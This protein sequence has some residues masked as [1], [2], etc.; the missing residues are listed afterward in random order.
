MT[1]LKSDVDRDATHEWRN[2][3]GIGDS[4][5]TWRTKVLN[6][7]LTIIS[8]VVLA[9]MA[10]V[11][12]N[13]VNHPEQWLPALIFLALYVILVG[14]AVFR[15]MDVRW[16]GWGLLLIGYLAGLVAFAR[17]GLA[18]AGPIYVLALSVLAIILVG[19]RSGVLM[20]ALNAATYLVL[21]FLADSGGLNH[22]LIYTDNPLTW[23]S[24]MVEGASLGMLWVIVIVLLAYFHQ[25]H[26]ETLAAERQASEELAQAYKL[27]EQHKLTLEDRVE[28]RTRQLR[29]ASQNMSRA[30]QAKDKLLSEFRA[31]LDIIEYSVLLLD[32]DLRTRA[33]N[34]AFREMWGFTEDF[35]A[36]S[37]TLAELITY[38]RDTGLYD[39]PE[40][41]WDDYVEQK[42]EAV[43]QGEIPPTT[44]KLGDGRILR[45]QAMRLPDDG[46]ILTYFDI[47]DLM[48]QSEY[49][50]VLHET[51]LG[52]ISRLDLG[53]LL[54]ALVRRAGQL[55]DTSH[56]FIYLTSGDGTA[57]ECRVGV[58]AFS[59][60]IDTRMAPGEGLSGKIWQ[61]GQPMIV[62]DYD[63]W[64]GRASSFE[65]GLIS[66]IMGAPL[67]SGAQT[68]GVIGIAYGSDLDR[69]F[70]DDEV[71]LLNRFAELA[72]IALDNAQL[73]QAAQ[74]EKRYFQSLVL[75]NPVAVIVTSREGEV[76]SWNPAAED[77]F[78]YTSEEAVGRNVDD[79][80]AN[81]ALR[82]EALGFTRRGTDGDIVH[83]ITRRCR[84]DGSLVDVELLAVPMHVEEEESST[85]VIYHDI[86]ELQQARQEA[87]AANQAKSAF[88]ATMSHEIRTPMNAVIGMTSLLLDTPLTLEQQEFVETIR[89][90]GDALLTIINDIL[91]F[92]KIE[93]GRMTLENQP[94]DLRECVEGALDL[95]AN[96]ALEKGLEIG[97]IFGDNTPQAIW[98]DVTRLRQILVNL[99]SNA[100]KF[101]E[102]GEVIVYVK[103]KGYEVGS[104]DPASPNIHPLLHF[105]VRDT[106]IGVPSD[107]MDRLFKSFTQVDAST[108]RRYGG[109]GLGLVISKRLCEMMGGQIWAESPPANL[110]TESEARSPLRTGG[111]EKDDR[112]PRA[113]GKGGPGSIFHF[114][115]RARVAPMPKPAYL[116][117]AQPDLKGRRALIVDDNATNRR[118]LT[119]QMQAWGMPTR[120][121]EFPLEALDWVR[122][123]DPFDVAV[124][125][126][127]MPQMDGLM[128]AQEIQRIRDAQILPLVMLTS[129]GSQEVKDE[130]Q[131]P[132]FAAF[133]TKPIKASH[134]YNVLVQIFAKDVRPEESA[135]ET[136]KPI[137]DSEMGRR[138][139]L[140]ILMA[141]DNV[142][143]QKLTSRLLERLGYRADVVG[144]GVE[145]LEA[146]RRQMYDMIL[147]DVQ[148]PEMDGLETT[149]R[150]HQECPAERRPRIVAMTAN[151]MKEDREACMAAGMDD[152]L[153]KPLR[154]EELVHALNMCQ[155]LG[156]DAIKPGTR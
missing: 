21:T 70:G 54:E 152:Y 40:G 107:R 101:T 90:S 12:A 35:V 86:T 76:L 88:L 111:A 149:R 139:P 26:M 25:F 113:P 136:R 140:R 5:Q 51:T 102:E 100:V 115:I 48:R 34:R 32:A 106:G 109:T 121:T 94:F 85:L 49:L 17:G 125:D 67:K 41:E 119:L 155:P 122:L 150:I 52:L 91:D 23:Q 14:L 64:S 39:V 31:V 20:G 72:S 77:L 145:A 144:N 130:A 127:Q 138:H 134:L 117:N 129:L 37:P 89:A 116:K 156:S 50:A 81:E 92:S 68:V 154:V 108:T 93:A 98:G 146:L 15:R 42:V 61:S 103:S 75:N 112:A 38:N 105:S 10:T 153:S 63:A 4:L 87:E 57:L 46:R 44:F 126:M 118:I 8:V 16:R 1:D 69:R 97:Y 123:G 99:L 6:I 142:V 18:G 66:A 104:E 114:T 60:L 11:A 59:H 47:T 95:V 53:D 55:L 148:M 36:R 110:P 2:G 132:E 84:R 7:L 83:A 120:A 3:D 82:S 58:G 80:V 128:L 131:G 9:P 65:Q 24:W 143:N 124:L 147:M 30:V 96:N 19:T 28:E 45:Y 71:K 29:A 62:D 133:L 78:G 22:W 137:F 141:E 43:R 79:L 135:L 27:V 151:A 74:R 13:A 33:V 73:Y 56:G